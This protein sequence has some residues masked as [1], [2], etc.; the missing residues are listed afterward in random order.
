MSYGNKK[1]NTRIFCSILFYFVAVVI[2]RYSFINFCLNN[3]A[4][5]SLAYNNTHSILIP[6]P[7]DQQLKLCSRL[8]VWLRSVH[9]S[10]FT[11]PGRRCSFFMECIC[12]PAGE[13]GQELSNT[14]QD[15]RLDICHA[16]FH[17]TCSKQ[18][19]RPEYNIHRVVNI[20][21]SCRSGNRWIFASH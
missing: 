21:L 7:V 9:T 14:E 13:S 10:S 11:H 3:N 12:L 2:M 6:R 8:Q 5:I 18:V 19:T 4:K 20:F 17:L 1:V 16:H 15:P